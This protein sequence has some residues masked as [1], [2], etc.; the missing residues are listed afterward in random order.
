MLWLTLFIAGMA[1]SGPVE[2]MSE[3]V[4]S[5]VEP[6]A[7][8]TLTYLN[9]ALVTLTA[10]AFFGGLYLYCSPYAPVWSMAGLLFVPVYATLNLFAYL[11]QVTIVPML[12]DRVVASGEGILLLAQ[13]VQQWPGS[14]ANIVNNT[15]YAV[16]AVPSIVYGVMLMNARPPM[17]L[18]GIMLGLSGLASLIGLAGIMA[19]SVT[20]GAGSVVSGGLFLLALIPL[21][22]GFL[23]H[24]KGDDGS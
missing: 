4:E 5:V 21:S 23:Q 20:L 7:L 9:A 3:A 13:L 19:K 12:V 6:G 8:Y 17:R 16:L 10:T 15:G 1:I 11:S 24:G 14:L 22:W 18:G 2:T